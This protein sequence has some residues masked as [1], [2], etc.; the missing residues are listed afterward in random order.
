MSKL[1]DYKATWAHCT[2]CDLCDSGRSQVVFSD[3]PETAEIMIIGEGPGAK[4]D[5][6]G[7]PFSGPAGQLMTRVLALAGIHRQDCYWTNAVRCW[8]QVS[9]KTKAPNKDELDSCKPLLLEEIRQIKPKVILLLGATAAK[10][11]L[12]HEGSLGSIVGEW[13]TINGIPAMTSWHPAAILHTQ[14]HDQDKCLGY[15]KD[16][17]RDVR[18]IRDMLAKIRKGN[19]PEINNAS[20]VSFEEQMNMM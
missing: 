11:M 5:Q 3:G 1:S 6:S 2:R 20:A 17:W 9:G 15:K 18:A 7:I 14:N 4:E 19:N 12:L 8:P 13:A 16:L 10:S